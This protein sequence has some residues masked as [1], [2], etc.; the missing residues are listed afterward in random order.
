MWELYRTNYLPGH[1]SWTYPSSNEVLDEAGV[2]HFLLALP[3][4]AIFWPFIL[5]LWTSVKPET[6][7]AFYINKQLK[8]LDYFKG[9]RWSLGKK[10]KVKWGKRSKNPSFRVLKINNALFTL[11]FILRP[12][13]QEIYIKIIHSKS[14]V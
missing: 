1:C 12:T 9:R 8:Y 11:L 3:K 13:K 7:T 6:G 4:L 14:Q 2:R 5:M 10:Q